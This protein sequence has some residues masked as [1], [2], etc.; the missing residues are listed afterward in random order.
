M[1]IFGCILQRNIVEL[2]VVFNELRI[3]EQPMFI[4]KGQGT[5]VG[6]TLT[7]KPLLVL[8]PGDNLS[9]E[10]GNCLLVPNGL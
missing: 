4:T 10:V 3:S 1:F 2:Y 9:G 8:S 7:S 5:I 6:N